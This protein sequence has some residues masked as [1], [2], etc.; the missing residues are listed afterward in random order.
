[1]LLTLDLSLPTSDLPQNQTYTSGIGQNRSTYLH[2]FQ[3]NLTHSYHSNTLVPLPD[4][5]TAAPYVPPSP[6][7]GDI[8]HIYAFYLFKQP[9][10]FVLT[11]VNAGRDLYPTVS[12]DRIGFSAQ[13]VAE[14][15]G[16]ELVAGTY[17]REQTPA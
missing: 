7:P 10:E 15:K 17:F 9:E 4:T 5:E 8:A 1:M 6:N 13:D 16:V 11:G 2:W 14:E 12:Y 3:G